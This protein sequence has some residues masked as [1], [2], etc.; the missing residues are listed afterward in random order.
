[1]GSSI[2]IHPLLDE[3]KRESSVS[4]LEEIVL[5]IMPTYYLP[6][7]VTG[8]EVKL[9]QTSWNYILG[10]KS[11]VYLKMISELNLIDKEIFLCRYENKCLNWFTEI[12]F[13]RFF[14]IHPIAKSLFVNK[15]NIVVSENYI[16]PN[17]NNIMNGMEYLKGQIVKVISLTLSQTKDTRKFIKLMKKIAISHC[18]RGVQAIEYGIMG[19]ALFYSL[20]KCLGPEHFT[21]A[22]DLA[23]KSMY[24]SMLRHIVPECVKYELEQRRK[25]EDYQ[26]YKSAEYLRRYVADNTFLGRLSQLTN[27]SRENSL[28]E[29]EN[30]SCSDVNSHLLDQEYQTHPATSI[31]TPETQTD[32]T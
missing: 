3:R 21:P 24:S 11:M 4:D 28:H 31:L 26:K 18:K 8:R 9:C 19:N 17:T 6:N 23:W 15:R 20:E 30:E 14:D 13:D 16:E 2:S 12:F 5:L 22:V 10:N 7:T 1:M 32:A 29:S 27:H 25:D